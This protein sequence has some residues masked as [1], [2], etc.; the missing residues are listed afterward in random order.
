M[1]VVISQP[2]HGH[3][4]A[5]MQMAVHPG[6]VNMV[7]IPQG[8]PPGLSYLGALNEVLIH[9]HFDVLEVVTGCERNNKYR[10]CNSAEQQ[11]MYA[12]EDTDCMTRQCCGTSRPFTI[13]ITD[14]NFQPLISVYRPFRC[15]GSCL[16]CC[17]L[18]EM[19]IQ[20]PPGNTIGNV[21]Q[22]WTCWTP[23]Y[24]VYDNQGQLVFT[25][26]G[27][28]CYCAPC[29]DIF[30]QVTDA[31]GQEVGRIIKNWG[32]CREILGGVNDFRVQFPPEMDIYKKSLLLGATFLI[33]FVYFERN[34]NN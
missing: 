3:K 13:N 26:N 11:F 20:S 25:I 27:E 15:V 12:K 23:K 29:T 32:G 30:F 22:I 2:G 31:S 34:K 6:D 7:I 19:D 21:K 10:L 17:C 24:E 1:S 18:Q 9:Q 14:N 33:D 16:W 8:L 28:C 5:E 4:G